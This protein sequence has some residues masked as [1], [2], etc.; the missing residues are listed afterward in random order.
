MQWKAWKQIFEDGFSCELRFLHIYRPPHP[1]MS[2]VGNIGNHSQRYGT[3][4]NKNPSIPTWSTQL[5]KEEY[6]TPPLCDVLPF[7]INNEN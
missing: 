7:K 2:P 1:K 6:G 5:F 4:Q 3:C